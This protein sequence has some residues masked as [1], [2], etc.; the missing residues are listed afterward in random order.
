MS[1]GLS[2]QMPF[3]V[4]SKVT[5]QPGCSA[6]PAC[7]AAQ[8]IP[9]R[10]VDSGPCPGAGDSRSCH[11]PGLRVACA[12]AALMPLPGVNIHR[13]LMWPHRAGRLCHIWH[14]KFYAWGE[15][16]FGSAPVIFLHPFYN[17]KIIP[18]FPNSLRACLHSDFILQS[19][20]G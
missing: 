3:E 2:T 13:R 9:P 6:G 8:G 10:D 19:S 11:H 14:G 15:K 20:F 18:K 5:T 12:R 16:S 1:L 17:P 4:W 7:L